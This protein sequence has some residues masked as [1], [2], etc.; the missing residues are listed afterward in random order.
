LKSC[1]T[2]GLELLS[3][4][5]HGTNRHADEPEDYNDHE[6]Q[7]PRNEKSRNP[8]EP[9]S[10]EKAELPH[11]VNPAD[12]EYDDADDGQFSVLPARFLCDRLASGKLVDKR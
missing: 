5:Y 6:V 7:Y 2:T 1:D 4:T 8:A 11:G 3:L 12:K 9:Q 10:E